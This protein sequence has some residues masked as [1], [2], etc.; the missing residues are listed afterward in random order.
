MSDRQDM[1]HE[2][3]RR[4]MNIGLGEKNRRR[5]TNSEITR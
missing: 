3:E 4:E 1:Q 2:W 5:E